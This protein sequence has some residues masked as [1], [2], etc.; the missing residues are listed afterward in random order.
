MKA[1]RWG[2][3]ARREFFEWQHWLKGA[4]WKEQVELH[5][6]YVVWGAGSL[7]NWA[8]L[9]VM[10]QDPCTWPEQWPW[11]LNHLRSFHEQSRL[12]E[13]GRTIHS[14]LL[15][16]FSGCWKEPLCYDSSYPPVAAYIVDEIHF[17]W[18]ENWGFSTKT[19]AYG[20]NWG[21]GR[22]PSWPLAAGQRVQITCRPCVIS[23]NLVWIDVVKI[24]EHL[25]WH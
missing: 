10:S 9:S 3:L 5:H 21:A 4:A 8:P 18:S 2:L 6:S 20:V 17:S 24:S 7:Q 22:Q 14:L 19:E 25:K 13:Q 12:Q 23:A 1:A 16:L 11:Q 15:C